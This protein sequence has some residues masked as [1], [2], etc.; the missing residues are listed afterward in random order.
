MSF[1]GCMAEDG[2][3]NFGLDSQPTQEFWEAVR[4]EANSP[5]MTGTL[6]D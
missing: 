2:Q 6:G 1:M 5:S 4:K 3:A